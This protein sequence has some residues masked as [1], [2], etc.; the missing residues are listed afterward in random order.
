[1][2]F[3]T[4]ATSDLDEVQAGARRL[5]DS[6]CTTLGSSDPFHMTVQH[7]DHDGWTR[8][9]VRF[10]AGGL[11]MAGHPHGMVSV[12]RLRAGEVLLTRRRDSLL[13][14]KGDVFVMADAVNTFT[15]DWS[16]ADCSM[17]RLPVE[18]LEE[19]ADPMRAGSGA[20]FAFL[21]SR[22]LTTGA[23]RR[24]ARVTSFADRHLTES[25]TATNRVM[26][27][28]V[29]HLLAAS[30]L[31]TFPTSLVPGSSTLPPRTDVPTTVALAV[32]FVARNADLPIRLADIAPHALVSERALQLAFRNHLATSPVEYLRRYRL[33]RVHEELAGAVPGDGTSVTQVAARWTFTESSRFVAHYRRMY[34]EQTSTT[35]PPDPVTGVG[36]CR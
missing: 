12:C 35:L 27:D 21:S 23:G 28:A 33:A 15:T 6:R 8:D 10:D 26:R 19:A 7:T 30:V 22:P 34:D 11:S 14:Q 13:L 18:A 4:F 9:G 20:P 17:L 32:D 3:S 1:M 31:T 5:Y 24:F 29:R 16:G 36:S 25:G 2:N